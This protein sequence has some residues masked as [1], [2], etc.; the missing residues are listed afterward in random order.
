MSHETI[1]ANRYEFDNES[2]RE[3]EWSW[4]SIEGDWKVTVADQGM[5]SPNVFNV[6]LGTDLYESTHAD[7]QIVSDTRVDLDEV[8]G[9]ESAMARAAELIA[10]ASELVDEG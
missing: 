2:R 10:D 3:D 1:T 8:I 5:T 4:H 9:Y 7:G 6:M